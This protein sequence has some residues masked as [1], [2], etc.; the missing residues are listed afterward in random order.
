M[1]EKHRKHQ[2]SYIEKLTRC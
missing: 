1:R 2:M